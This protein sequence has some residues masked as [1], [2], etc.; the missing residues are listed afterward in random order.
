MTDWKPPAEPTYWTSDG[1]ISLYGI[2]TE[3]WLCI[4]CG[5]NTAP[6]LKTRTEKEAAIKALGALW[7][8]N[9]AGIEEHVGRNSEIYFVRDAVWKKAGMTGKWGEGC[10]CI[11]CLEQRIGRRLKPKDFPRDHE[12]NQLPGTPRLMQR[13]GDR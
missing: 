7:K 3:N 8:H 6:G 13:R 4:D 2:S 10:L 11:G 12:F 5:V 1:T 9:L